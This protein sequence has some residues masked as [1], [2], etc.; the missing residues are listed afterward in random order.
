GIPG[1]AT[2][3]PRVVEEAFAPARVDAEGGVG[4]ERLAGW[5]LLAR[6]QV[7][8]GTT[9]GRAGFDAEAV[10][11]RHGEPR[12]R[13]AALEHRLRRRDASVERWPL[14]VRF[15]RGAQHGLCEGRHTV[16]LQA[17]APAGGR[18]Q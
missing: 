12:G 3:D 5:R 1:E 14:C 6:L 18:G 15:E 4:V 11:V 2:D 13:V 9:P 10:P 8:R 17:N 7:D 16:S